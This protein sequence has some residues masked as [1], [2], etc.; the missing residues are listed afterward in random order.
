MRYVLALLA[1]LAWGLW[2]GGMV[3][4]FLFVSYLFVNDRATA[5]VAAPKMFLVFERYQFVIATLAIVSSALWRLVD[6]RRTITLLFIFFALSAVGTIL[7]ATLIRAPMENLRLEGQSSRPEFQRLHKASEK[8]YTVQAVLLLVGGI[9]LPSAMR[10]SPR[11]GTGPE[12][13]SLTAP[14][15]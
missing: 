10:I 9:M 2:F 4:L 14:P 3:A 11:P 8:L 12:A 13:E 15:V 7:S 5:I 1:T 6:K